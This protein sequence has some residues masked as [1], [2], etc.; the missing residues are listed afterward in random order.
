MLC[1]RRFGRKENVTL[2]WKG[3]KANLKGKS[4]TVSLVSSHRDRKRY[5][6]CGLDSTDY[7]GAVLRDMKG[8]WGTVGQFANEERRV[9]MSRT[10]RHCARRAK[11]RYL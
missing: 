5:T 9:D 6:I 3:K 4:D 2:V 7:I 1:S 10:L 11:S 8:L